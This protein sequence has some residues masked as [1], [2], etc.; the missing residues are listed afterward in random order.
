MKVKKQTLNKQN[1]PEK[2]QY[3]RA[4]NNAATTAVGVSVDVNMKKHT[5]THEINAKNT[6]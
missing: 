4:V 1:T 6:H 3:S 2:Q 5:H